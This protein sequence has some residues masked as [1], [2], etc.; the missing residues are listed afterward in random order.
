MNKKHSWGMTARESNT[1]DNTKEV[2]VITRKP[3][4]TD[5][6]V[7]FA[8]AFTVITRRGAP[9]KEAFIHKYMTY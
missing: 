7:G 8:G 9:L 5:Q 3:T 4:L 2:T 1:S 6:K